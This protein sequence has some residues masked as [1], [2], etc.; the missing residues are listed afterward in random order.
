MSKLT[1]ER[2]NKVYDKL[3]GNACYIEQKLPIVKTKAN[4][5]NL[6]EKANEYDF[7]YIEERL[8][9]L[10][11]HLDEVKREYLN[12]LMSNDTFI[13]LPK[14]FEIINYDEAC[15]CD[16]AVAIQ[17]FNRKK[18]NLPTMIYF[19]KEQEKDSH[20]YDNLE[21]IISEK[22]SAYACALEIEKIQKKLKSPENIFKCNIMNGVFPL[23][24][25]EPVLQH[26]DDCFEKGC[27]PF[28]FV[29]AYEIG[30]YK[31]G[32]CNATANL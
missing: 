31:Q 15:N 9:L 25:A 12:I 16:N 27:R 29:P 17:V 11:K 3:Y 1:T 7:R 13:R 23:H 24:E 20:F 26:L 10:S 2:V 8:I 5:K 32:T 21:F 28:E 4:L 30:I 6:L 19:F 18:L 22:H 14:G